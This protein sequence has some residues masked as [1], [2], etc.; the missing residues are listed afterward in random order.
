MDILTGL[1]AVIPDESSVAT[2][3]DS[4]NKRSAALPAD[5]S[6]EAKAWASVYSVLALSAE[7]ALI[8]RRLGIAV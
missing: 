3:A 8:Q 5:G 4:F 2:L 7:S 1:L 6:S